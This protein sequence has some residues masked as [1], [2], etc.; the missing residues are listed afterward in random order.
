M[1]SLLFLR[2]RESKSRSATVLDAASHF[3]SRVCNTSLFYTVAYIRSSPPGLRISA[4]ELC[5]YVA[6]A[7]CEYYIDNRMIATDT[8]ESGW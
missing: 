5:L 6:P 1:P 4:V 3:L 2:S 8:S 7:M